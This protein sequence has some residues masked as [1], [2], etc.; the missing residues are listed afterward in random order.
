MAMNE[1]TYNLDG[2]ALDAWLDAV[3]DDNYDPCPC[4]C[5][6][7]FRYILRYSL[8]D[9]ERLEEHENKFKQDWKQNHE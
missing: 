3:P 5:G 2:L 1:P 7:K 9:R 4:G 8:K 6:T